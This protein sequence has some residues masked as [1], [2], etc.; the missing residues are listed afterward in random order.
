[1][2]WTEL[3]KEIFEICIIPLIGVLTGFLIKVIKTKSEELAV[4]TDNEIAQKYIKMLTQTVSDC[5]TAT[6]QTYVE[7]LKEKG[8]FG[9]EAQ[10]EAFE[11][12][13]QSILAILSEDALSY[14]EIIYEDF[15]GYLANK[16]EAEVNVQK[17]IKEIY[18]E[19]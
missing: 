4:K 18:N 5:V 15:H 13:Y 3:L 17:G 1:M 11:R 14:L 16:I 12:T 7:A 8:E 9:A 6:N 2:E 19:V 10:K